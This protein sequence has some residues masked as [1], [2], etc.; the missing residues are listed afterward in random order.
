MLVTRFLFAV[1]LYLDQL[2]GASDSHDYPSCGHL[3]EFVPGLGPRKASNLL[4]ELG[5][6]RVFSRE[7]LLQLPYWGKRVHANA[8]PFLRFKHRLVLCVSLE[9]HM[10]DFYCRDLSLA[11]EDNRNLLDMTLIHPKHYEFA[12]KMCGDA[13]EVRVQTVKI[14]CCSSILPADS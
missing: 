7:G 3:L 12:E 11:E 1:L 14:M 2:V 10:N 5:R 9:G 13:L 8:A 6:R 4:L